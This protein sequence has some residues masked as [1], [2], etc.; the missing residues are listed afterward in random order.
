MM[1]FL[2]FLTRKTLLITTAH[3]ENDPLG[4]AHFFVHISLILHLNSECGHLR[5]F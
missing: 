1:V 3:A 5:D 2:R 4:K